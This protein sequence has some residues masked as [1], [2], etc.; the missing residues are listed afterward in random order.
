MLSNRT[1]PDYEH[2]PV[3]ETVMDVGFAPLQGWGIPHFGLFWQR[4]RSEYPR[5]EDQPPVALQLER[6]G[7]GARQQPPPPFMFIEQPEARCWFFDEGDARL[8]QVQNDRFIHNW[9]KVTSADVY[10]HYEESIRPSFERE[11]DRFC[12][13]LADE[14][15][16][17]PEIKQCE[18]SYINHIDVEAT[19]WHSYVNLIDALSRWPGGASEGF[20]PEPETGAFNTNYLLPSN[21]GRLR[22]QVQPVIRHSDLKQVIQLAL[23]VRGQP[24]SSSTEE[25]LKWFDVGREWIVRGFTDFTSEKMHQRWGRRV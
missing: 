9:R 19:V 1:L 12:K 18:I 17:P 10:P 20:L 14:E 8:I 15:I 13:Y 4:I 11:W 7:E 21:S 6:Y 24:A 2:P 23:I 3:T 5:F 22:I 25:I 16:S